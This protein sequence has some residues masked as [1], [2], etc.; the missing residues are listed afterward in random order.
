[1]K[2]V[3]MFD[4]CPYLAKAILHEVDLGI[5]ESSGVIYRADH[6]PPRLQAGA[7]LLYS[8]GHRGLRSSC[9]GDKATVRALPSHSKAMLRKESLAACKLLGNLVPPRGEAAFDPLADIRIG[10]DR[11]T[12]QAFAYDDEMAALCWGGVPKP[13]STKQVVPPQVP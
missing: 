8:L 12:A 2:H 11:G 4:N 7:R 3:L 10:L 13:D 5:I 6:A 1:M 9:A